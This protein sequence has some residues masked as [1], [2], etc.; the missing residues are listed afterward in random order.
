[1]N[2]PLRLT[3]LRL[4]ASCGSALILAGCDLRFHC[5]ETA[6]CP[7]GDVCREHICVPDPAGPGKGPRLLESG[8]STVAAGPRS[9]GRIRIYDDGF[10]GG[11]RVCSSD[12]ETCVTGAIVP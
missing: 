5:G 11:A 3:L 7:D 1:M 10:E 12:G 8:F 2:N 4:A 9:T 6:Q